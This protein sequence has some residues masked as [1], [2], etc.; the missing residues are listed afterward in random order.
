MFENILTADFWLSALNHLYAFTVWSIALLVI[1]ENRNPVKTMSWALVL[2]LIPY[3]GLVLYIFFGQNYRRQK[4]ISRKSIKQIELINGY[5]ETLKSKFSIDGL[6]LSSVYENHR[7]LIS[8]LYR[9]NHSLITSRNEIKILHNGGE[10]FPALLDDLR[11]ATQFIHIEYYIFDDD[12]IGNTILTILREK[13]SEGVEVRLIVDDVGS[14]HL[15]RRFFKKVRSYGIEIHAFLE[16]RFPYFTSKINYRNHRKI[17]VIDG[18][19]GYTGGLNVADRY[20]HGVEELGPWRD[21]HLRI[22]GDAVNALQSIFILDWYF[23]SQKRIK[24][25]KYFPQH[26]VNNTNDVNLQIAWSSPDSDWKSIEQAF[27]CLITSAKKYIYIQSP[28]FLPTESIITA[29]KTAS[30]SGIDVRIM[31]PKKSD[32]FITDASSHSYLTEILEAGVRVYFY[33]KGFL[34]SKILVSDDSIASVGS[35]NMDFRSFEDNFE[36]SAFIYDQKAAIDLRNSFE[37][38]IPAS[39][40]LVLSRWKRRKFHL[41]LWES[42]ARLFS[43]LL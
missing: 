29:L 13:V 37:N 38:D 12:T 30:L 1:L 36:V 41:K 18:R 14:W 25:Q 19:I 16:V 31:I 28:Y 20:I 24:D 8:L 9:N 40:E 11:N 35:A 33:D 23:V 15:K 5:Y 34:H 22:E 4:I 21:I 3:F 17:V 10:K 42:I 32:A 26:P 43:P 6:T 39:V 7:K 2:V 27:F